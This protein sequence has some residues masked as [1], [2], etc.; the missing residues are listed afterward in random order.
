M[1]CWLACNVDTD[2]CCTD[3]DFNKVEIKEEDEVTL[4]QPSFES[5]E[6]QEPDT[7][8]IIDEDDTPAYTPRS[9]SYC[10]PEEEVEDE[11][12]I[13]TSY[14]DDRGNTVINFDCK[15]RIFK[16]VKDGDYPDECFICSKK[17]KYWKHWVFS[18]IDESEKGDPY[19]Y[20]VRALCDICYWK[21]YPTKVDEIC[22]KSCITPRRP[23]V[24]EPAKKK[25]R[26]MEQFI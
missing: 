7:Q 4:H 5:Q 6:T 17:L 2:E 10:P 3:P 11:D 24:E 22:C 26:T 15:Q 9:P 18:I 20:V 16:R 1:K 21:I 13:E 25:Q 23:A 14:T 8:V 19:A 12:F